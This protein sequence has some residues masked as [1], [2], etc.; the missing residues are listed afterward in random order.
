MVKTQINQDILLKVAEYLAYDLKTDTLNAFKLAF[1]GI[2]EQVESRVLIEF[3]VKNLRQAGH[4]RLEYKG[5]GEG[6]ELAD[7]IL[8]TNLKDYNLSDSFDLSYLNDEDYVDCILSDSK[9][10][11]LAL[12]SYYCLDDLRTP[13]ALTEMF[14]ATLFKLDIDAEITIREFYKLLDTMPVLQDLRLV[15]IEMDEGNHPRF[16]NDPNTVVVATDPGQILVSLADNKTWS[17]GL[18][19]L[20]L[21]GLYKEEEWDEDDEDDENSYRFDPKPFTNQIF[22]HLERLKIKNEHWY[23]YSITPWFT[24]DSKVWSSLTDLKIVMNDLNELHNISRCCPN[25][26]NASFTI[27]TELVMNNNIHIFFKVLTRSFPYLK[28]LDFKYVGSY[29]D[30]YLLFGGR[31]YN[32]RDIV[33]GWLYMDVF[34]GNMVLKKLA[35]NESFLTSA[36]E[37]MKLC[38][39]AWKG[40]TRLSLDGPVLSLLVLFPLSKLEDL[41]HLKLTLYSLSGMDVIARYLDPTCLDSHRSKRSRIGQAT[42]KCFK[43]I[44][45]LDLSLKEVYPHCEDVYLFTKLFPSMEKITINKS[46]HVGEPRLS[47][48]CSS[49]SKFYQ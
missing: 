11:G 3:D 25:L 16:D 37:S 1:P 19:R 35:H 22:P 2:K 33:F 45:E 20:E 36:I 44:K 7:H 38:D 46:S 23:P 28:S 6:H 4:H 48:I 43:N 21:L 39:V 17:H 8:T 5:K 14:G 9:V 40:L 34:D 49:C 13:L 18:R 32:D 29:Y 47:K 10:R 27:N 30:P 31:Q 24:A 12:H 42:L 26:V 41:E 15:H